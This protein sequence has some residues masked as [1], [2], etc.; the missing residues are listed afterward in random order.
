MRSQLQAAGLFLTLAALAACGTAASSAGKPNAVN[1]AAAGGVIQTRHTTLGTV[2][3]TA[4]GSTIYWS[5]T[6]TTK[7]ALCTGGCAKYWPPVKGPV[8]MAAGLKLPGK[9]GTITRPGGFVQATYDGHPLYTYLADTTPGQTDGNMLNENGGLFWAMT[10][11]ATR[12]GAPAGSGSSAPAPPPS[13][14]ASQP[15]PPRSAPPPSLPP[16]GYGY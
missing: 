14:S 13:S 3:T 11:S 16:G 6:D 8:T 9:L 5:S 1:V 10:P 2:L 7:A 12:I 4:R 15:P